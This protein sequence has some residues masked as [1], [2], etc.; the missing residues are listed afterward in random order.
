R[1]GFGEV[2]EIATDAQLVK[3][4]R[5]SR[6]VRVPSSPNALA[7]ALPANHQLIE[8]LVIELELAPGAQLFDR[9]HEDEVSRARAVAWRSGIWKNENLPRLEMSRGLQSDRGSA[10]GGILSADRHFFYLLEN[11][12]VQRAGRQLTVQFFRQNGRGKKNCD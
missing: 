2:V 11:D 10:R 8:R 6:S 9:F 4:A 3:Q 12:F 7:V 1:L 5:G